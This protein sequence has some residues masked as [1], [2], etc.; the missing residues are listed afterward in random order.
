MIAMAKFEV[1]KV[2][3]RRLEGQ[4]ERQPGEG[5][6]EILETVAKRVSVGVW[7]NREGEVGGRVATMEM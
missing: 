1:L 3:G 7:G 2:F 5:Y 6:E 4:V